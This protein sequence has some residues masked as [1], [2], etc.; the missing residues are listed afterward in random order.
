M[1]TLMSLPMTASVLISKTIC[2]LK[3]E[4]RLVLHNAELADSVVYMD[5]RIS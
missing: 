5:H 1:D 3:G 4:D 2:L